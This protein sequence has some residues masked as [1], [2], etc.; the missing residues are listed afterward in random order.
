MPGGARIHSIL[1]PKGGL[2]LRGPMRARQTAL[3]VCIVLAILLNAVAVSA[4]AGLSLRWHSGLTHRAARPFTMTLVPA[5]VPAAQVARGLASASAARALPSRQP[6]AGSSR[7][8]PPTQPGDLPT[9]V[10]FYT[11][12]EVDSPAAPVSDWN[13]D[14]ADLDEIGVHRLVFE[15]LVSDHGE[16]VLC[17][18]LDPV[19]LD[20]EVRHRLEQRLS[21]TNLE[22]ALR[23]RRLVA[24]VRRIELLLAS[25]Q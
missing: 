11:F 25:E 1:T 13:I 19:G 17:T 5:A 10:R 3:A 24:S 9:E 8:G 16:I 20:D 6:A 4:V 23:A 2:A 7:A 14:V 21:A 18:V 15:V 12:S 22:P